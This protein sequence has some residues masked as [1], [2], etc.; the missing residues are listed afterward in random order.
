M[1]TLM[2]EFILELFKK[3][4]KNM[5]DDEVF[6]E[7]KKNKDGIYEKGY[8]KFIEPEEVYKAVAYAGIYVG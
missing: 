5:T 7:I 6:A 2:E 1:R 3:K 8:K 4:D